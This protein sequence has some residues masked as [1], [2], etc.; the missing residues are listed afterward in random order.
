MKVIGV[1]LV[2]AGALALVYGG[3]NYS[4]QRT[5][6]DVGPIKATTT[7]HRKFPVSPILGVIAVIGGILLVMTPARRLQ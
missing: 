4:R 6:L 3:I 2:V 1:V 5:I 7:E